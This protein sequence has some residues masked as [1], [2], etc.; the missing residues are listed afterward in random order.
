M[1]QDAP[2]TV[3]Y[4]PKRLTGSGLLGPVLLFSD[5]RYERFN[6][7]NQLVA[8]T[9]P[10]AHPCLTCCSARTNKEARQFRTP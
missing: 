3:F 8:P 4:L 5:R 1:E 9:F 2:E 6:S 10:A 7:R